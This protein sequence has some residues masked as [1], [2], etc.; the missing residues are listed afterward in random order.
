MFIP[1]QIVINTLVKPEKGSRLSRKVNRRRQLQTRRQLHVNN[2]KPS[3]SPTHPLGLV[4]CS[5]GSKKDVDHILV[6][7]VNGGVKWCG[8]KFLQQ[9]SV[10][11]SWLVSRDERVSAQSTHA[12]TGWGEPSEQF[13]EAPSRNVVST[14]SSLPA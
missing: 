11:G 8:A 13:T 3:R 10:D 9:T 2:S 6:I 12:H 1:Q 5:T 4:D 7:V 14:S